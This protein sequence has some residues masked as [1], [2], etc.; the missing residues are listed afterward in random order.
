[1]RFVESIKTNSSLTQLN[2]KLTRWLSL[3]V[4]LMALVALLGHIFSIPF[5]TGAVGD[6]P[7]MR[8]LSGLALMLISIS[9]LL[10]TFSRR[11]ILLA[12]VAAIFCIAVG[13]FTL[14]GYYFTSL[15]TPPSIQA[16][17]NFVLLGTSALVY[18]FFPRWIRFA[19]YIP[20]F[21]GAT[22]EIALTA[23]IFNAADM[24][25]F[26]TPPSQMSMS[27]ITSICFIIAS[28]ALL[29]SH[30]EVGITQLLFSE[31]SRSG[32]IARK[33]FLT[34]IFGPLVIGTITHLGLELNFYNERMHDALFIVLFLFVIVRTTWLAAKQYEALEGE[35]RLSEAKARGIIS[36]STDA[37]ISIDLEQNITLFNEA[38]EK[39]FGYTKN[40]ILGSKIDRL[41]PERFR[42]I[43]Q[44]DVQ[45]FS[46]NYQSARRMGERDKVIYGLRKNGEEFP[47]DAAISKIEVGGR[48]MMSVTLRDIT[49]RLRVEKAQG[50]LTEVSNTL[51]EGLILEKTL[52]KLAKLVVKN[53]ADYCMLE[54]ALE[55]ERPQLKI[56]SKSLEMAEKCAQ[57][58]VFSELVKAQPSP[59]SKMLLKSK[60][61]LLIEHIDDD[62]IV[63]LTANEQQHKHLQELAIT[64][65]I[66]VPLL[67]H[68]KF[69]G[70]LVM[71]SSNP[72]QHYDNFDF[73]LA[74]EL[75]SRAALSIE[76]S[77]LYEV[78]QKAI[79]IREE[80]LTVVSHDLK[81]P[82]TAIKLV[83][84]TL[85]LLESPNKVTCDRLASKIEN[86][87]KQ[88]HILINDLLDFAKIKSGTFSVSKQTEDLSE[89]IR[90]TIEALQMQA[91]QHQQKLVTNFSGHLPKVNIDGARFNQVIS[92]L[93]GNALKFSPAGGTITLTAQPRSFH[94]LISVSDNGPGIPAEF[95]EKIFDRFFQTEEAKHKGSGLGLSIVK[96]I[97]VAHGGQ[98]WVDSELGKGST[99]YFTVPLADQPYLHQKNIDSLDK[100]KFTD[101]SENTLKGSKILVVDDSEDNLFLIKNFL[102]KLG[103]EIHVAESVQSALS[104]IKFSMPHLLLTDIDMPIESGYDLL[105]HLRHS[106]DP[107]E[108]HLPVVALTGHC[109]AEEVERLKKAGF[110]NYLS[111]PL[112]IEKMIS[113]IMELTKH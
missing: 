52:Q 43:H 28:L 106:A 32:V 95:K 44:I 101:I 25:G 13:S 31:K 26:P 73:R 110:D 57:C 42:F 82:L 48:I 99:F 29:C 93:I 107:E 27:V 84:Q 105:S 19:Q 7:A 90:T 30:I 79:S 2:V 6:F 65:L 86:S 1:M 35:L 96:G 58:D 60:E 37:I 67:A 66:S 55:N 94:M 74:V 24:Q 64:S 70:T 100:F 76:N 22:A 14:L 104:N 34:I 50:I 36:M 112:D 63:S 68:N 88:M 49:E 16:S 51:S 62:H 20:L 103:A 15:G 113:T 109:E 3:T 33:L 77:Y 85:Q 98:I 8:P 39:I 54:I 45:D 46:K 87:A 83:G 59:F 111:K 5:L 21:V 9:I 69:I 47:A 10:T 91:E 40:E 23:N 72:R 102:E 18:L 41:I 92:N 53:L 38:A 75:A 4:F 17:L 81:N 61:A 11:L 108:S 80:I 89:T 56:V 78:S 71:I 12:S 97:V